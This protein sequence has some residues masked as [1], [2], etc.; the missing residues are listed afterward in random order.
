MLIKNTLYSI[1]LFIT[2]AYKGMAQGGG[3]PCAVT[4]SL[5]ISTTSISGTSNCTYSI[6]PTVTINDVPKVI[7]Y[8]FTVGTTTQY[9]CYLYN[10]TS[11]VLSIQSTGCNSDNQKF[12]KGSTL[13]LPTATLIFPCSSSPVVSP[14][15]TAYNG[16]SSSGTT[17]QCTSQTLLENTILPVK[18]IAFEGKNEQDKNRLTWQTASEI[19]SSRFAIQRSTDAKDF[20]EIGSVNAAENSVDILDYE[21]IDFMPLNGINYYR[22]KQIDLDNT[23]TLSKII[24]VNANERTSENIIKAYPNPLKEK[25]IIL[26]NIDS[27]ENYLVYSQTGELVDSK[28]EKLNNNY[29]VEFSERPASGIYILKTSSNN[30][31]TSY[32]IVVE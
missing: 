24:A 6:T 20:E 10:G 2:I 19:N 1:L 3:S 25:Y 8:K 31:S 13:T 18:L 15:M 4:S 5:N 16:A 23:I 22:L 29:I 27:L 32:R 28:I 12:P 26:S 21:Y 9:M 11:A 7:E 17:G 14:V 30:K